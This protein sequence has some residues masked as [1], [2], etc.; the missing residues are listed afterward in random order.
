V[1]SSRSGFGLGRRFGPGVGGRIVRA[2]P[3]YDQQ[4]ADVLDGRRAEFGQDL[5]EQRFPRGPVVVEHADLDQLVRDQVD[6]D[7]SQHGRREAIVTDHHDR[8]E[9]MG[10]G[11]QRAPGGRREF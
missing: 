7:L 11:A 10:L 1:A 8:I 5:R 3:E 6:L 2:G 9:V 4:L